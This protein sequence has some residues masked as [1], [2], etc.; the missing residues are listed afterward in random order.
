MDSPLPLLTPREVF[1]LPLFEGFFVVSV[2]NEESFQSLRLVQSYNC[3]P[4]VGDQHV[5]DWVQ[6]TI[7]NYGF[8][9]LK[10]IVVHEHD[11]TISPW[12]QHVAACITAVAS[13][14]AGAGRHRVY[15]IEGGATAFFNEYPALC[16]KGDV[17]GMEGPTPAHVDTFVFLGSKLHSEEVD[18]I[19]RL[20]CSNVLNCSQDLPNCFESDN[21]AVKARYC[22]LPIVDDSSQDMTEAIAVG[23]EFLRNCCS[24][25]ERVLIH[26]AEGKSRS[27]TIVIAFLMQQH[28]WS[29]FQALSHV[30]AARAIVQP[31]PGFM[32]QLAALILADPY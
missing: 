24:R 6:D 13:Q 14:V 25:G 3:P 31:N 21:A 26:C 1:N 2:A 10:T 12:L 30:Q 7:D 32:R 29:H 4:S 9:T 19:S 17:L 16:H 23:T 20:G 28:G 27:A 22:R 8:E 11:A 5:Q 15:T 18:V